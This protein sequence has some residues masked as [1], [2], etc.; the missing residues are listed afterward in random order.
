MHAFE[1]DITDTFF[2]IFEYSIIH[3]GKVKVELQ[4]EKKETMLIGDYTIN[5]MVEAECDRC[6]DPVDVEV[7]GT[8]QLVYKFDTQPSD[9]ESLIIVYPEEHEIDV[10]EN[11][12]ELITVSLPTRAIHEEGECNEEMISILDEYVLISEEEEANASEGESE[13][14]PNGEEQKE[15]IDPRWSAL[16]KLKAEAK[17]S[18][19][20]SKGDPNLNSSK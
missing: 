5:G 9:D 14:A 11:I 4:L 2:E 7:N 3:K 15:D 19:G 18:D 6:N 13:D 17:A 10:K 20:K 1:F 16:S 12:L 8:Y